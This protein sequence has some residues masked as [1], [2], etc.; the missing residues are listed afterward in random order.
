VRARAAK[1]GDVAA[2]HALLMQCKLP[3]DGVPGDL[4]LLLVA[5]HDGQVIGVAGLE[6]YGSDGLLRS[7]ATASSRRGLGIATTLCS[8]VESRARALGVARFYL[9]TETAE[10]FFAQR[11][12]AAIAR[13]FAPAPI[14]ASREFAVVC[15]ASASLMVREA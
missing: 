8:E 2:I 4:A 10:K 3:L 6:R 11:G 13:R 5:E 14:A 7:V 9:L 12:Y 1:L 15:P